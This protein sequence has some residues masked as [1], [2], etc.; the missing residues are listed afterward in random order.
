[1]WLR[2]VR[3]VSLLFVTLSLTPL[4]AHCANSLALR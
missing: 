2:T 1:M 4:F 3:F